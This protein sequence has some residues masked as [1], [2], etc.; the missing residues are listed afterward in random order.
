MGLGPGFG[1]ALGHRRSA[2]VR[3]D[4]PPY[5]AAIAAEGLV[6]LDARAEQQLDRRDEQR[7]RADDGGAEH[8]ARQQQ[9]EAQ[10]APA[11]GDGGWDLAR[12]HH[13]CA[14]T[15]LYRREAKVLRFVTTAVKSLLPPLAPGARDD[16]L[17][18]LPGA[19]FGKPRQLLG[20]G[21]EALADATRRLVEVR[22]D[23]E[24]HV[25][26]ARRRGGL[27]A[28]YF[29]VITRE[30]KTMCRFTECVDSPIT[31]WSC[32]QR[33]PSFR[34]VQLCKFVSS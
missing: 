20:D 26:A 22:E 5:D 14:V 23:K 21:P 17:A 7:R 10:K 19:R 4:T 18:D 24:A 25:G 28:K 3:V 15:V 16:V 34:S 6:H 2:L 30:Q 1:D 27:V 8:D 11:Q 32:L 13:S 31:A 29:Q 9:H 12:L 33:V